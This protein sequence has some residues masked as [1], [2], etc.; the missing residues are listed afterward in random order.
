MVMQR[1]TAPDPDWP[2]P[3]DRL[4]ETPPEGRYCDLILNGGV[5]SGVVYPWALLGLARQYRFRRIGGN[6]VGAMAAA[7]A[8][9]A[10]YGRCH[11]H[12]DAFEPLRHMPLNL[13]E[14]QP[15]GR[16]K[17][18]D[19]FQAPASL[20]RLFKL[21]VFATS[22]R[23][24]G[25]RL[26]QIWRGLGEAGLQRLCG[27]LAI[28]LAALGA[29]GCSELETV[30]QSA[31]SVLFQ[32]INEWL[33]HV[34]LSLP[35]AL[36]LLVVQA[37]LFLRADLRALRANGW[38]LCPGKAQPGHLEAL[39]EWLHRGIQVS[40]GR[41]REDPPLTFAELW[42]VPRAGRAG[43]APL[44]GGFE[45]PEAGI[46]L[47]M[48]TSNV[49]QGR[50]VRL[51]MS[52][53]EPRLFF[54]PKQWAAYFPEA[55]MKALK[56]VARPYAPASASDPP[57]E[58]GAGLFELP[59][60]DLPLVVAVRLSL[61]FPLL[62]S[63]V[64]L[65]AIDYEARREDRVLRLCQFSDGGL[66]ANFP[67]HLFD[68][69]MPQWPTFAL[70]LDRRLKA[71]RQQA[72]WL[73]LGEQQGRGD[74]WQRG[75]PGAAEDKHEDAKPPLERS[76]DKDK[77]WGLLLGMLATAK[78]WNDRVT[79]RLPQVRN[80]TLRFALKE[81][82]GQLNIGM[83]RERILSMA[84]RYGETASAE[85]LSAYAPRPSGEPQ[86]AWVQ[87]KFVRAM[88]E[89]RALR[90]HLRG[91]GL[92][93]QSQADGLDLRALLQEATRRPLLIRSFND[94]R[95]GLPELEAEDAQALARVVTAME[96]LE[97]ELAACGDSLERYV[98]DP[99]PELRLR[100]PV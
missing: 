52:Q 28:M 61:S 83:P 50:P 72:V 59:A 71:Y 54:S 78:D 84:Y 5:A 21:F 80:R 33:G 97:T 100:A 10:E 45:P 76:R 22:D 11:G 87:H 40:A 77:P 94:P 9:A 17:M 43:P 38:G 7:I 86:P 65:Y 63:C 92:S 8:A 53:Q 98:P 25:N 47:Q 19:L 96:A 3:P 99:E 32:S 88:V 34:V 18:L 39:M 69:A 75:V 85:L 49:T 67:V 30:G 23:P 82:E 44:R 91:F 93:A 29:K 36:L 55:I 14:A 64:P 37:G 4:T 70:L 89:M 12:A 62:F 74:N 57:A 16:T 15:G 48:F 66:C 73:P 58:R 1:A 51:P 2:P 46:S 60:G 56:P 42:S 90:R 20:Q 68:A 35:L 13:A 6:S 26:V 79:G 41:H 24:P 95:K 27:L 31:C 81:G